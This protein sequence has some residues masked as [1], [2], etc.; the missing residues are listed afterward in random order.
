MRVWSLGQENPLE[1]GMAA[2]SSRLE[3]GRP[4]PEGHK[5]SD[6]EAAD[7]HTHRSSLKNKTRTAIWPT[8]P[9][10]RH[11]FGENSH[12]KR[13]MHPSVHFSTIH[14]IHNTG[15]TYMPINRD[16][17]R[18]MWYI[19]TKE[20]YSVIGK[21][22]NNA[23]CSNKDG[24]RYYHFNWNK[25]EKYKCYMIS[26]TCAI[27]K[28]ETNSNPLVVQSLGLCAFTARA[29]VQSLVKEL[30]FCKPHDRVKNKW[31]YKGNN[32]KMFLND[33]N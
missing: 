9:S 27:L 33:T 30:R 4:R 5:E 8:S 14:N 29:Q 20:K 22:W 2:Y 7:T 16:W 28:N 17:I 23:I 31:T 25:S 32:F 24:P 18:K 21:E 26:L 19:H 15:T 1:K 11:V 3:P 6:P 12:W 10:P 13:Y